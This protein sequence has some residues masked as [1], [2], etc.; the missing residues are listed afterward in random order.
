MNKVD[1][2]YLSA[3]HVDGLGTL[4]VA[5][6]SSSSGWPQSHVAL[7]SLSSLI[8]FSCLSTILLLQ[9]QKPFPNTNY[10]KMSHSRSLQESNIV[11]NRAARTIPELVSEWCGLPLPRVS[12]V[13]RFFFW[14]MP[15]AIGTGSQV[16]WLSLPR[17]S[18]VLLFFFL[19][20]AACD[21]K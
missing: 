11:I 2:G 21:W 5:G 3:S 12:Y 15:R 13:L 20:D 1:L 10:T 6:L 18:Y 4:V 17:V 16:R 9:I 19:A 8:R 14:L 7:T